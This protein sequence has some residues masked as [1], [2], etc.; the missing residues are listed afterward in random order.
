MIKCPLCRS[1]NVDP[2]EGDPVEGNDEIYVCADC[3]FYFVPSD[4]WDY[5]KERMTE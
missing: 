3:Q 1:D 5:V 4:P 2:V